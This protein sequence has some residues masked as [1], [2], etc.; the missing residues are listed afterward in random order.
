MK[1]YILKILL[2]CVLLAVCDMAVGFV[3]RYLSDH[4]KVGDMK[5]SNHVVR[6]VD[7]DVLLMGSSRCA[8]HYDPQIIGEAL[9]TSCYNI[10]FDGNGIFLMYGRYKLMSERYTPKMI[11]Y[12]VQY[13]FDVMQ[14]DNHKYLQ[15]LRPYYDNGS[16]KEIVNS[17]GD[18]ENIKMLSQCY[19]FNNQFV[20][21]IANNLTGTA[22]SNGL[23]YSPLDYDI[24]DCTAADVVD[25]PVVD[26]LK[27]YYMEQ[28][29]KD[30]QGKTKLVFCSSPRYL[31][32]KG[33]ETD[34]IAA[35]CEKYGVPFLEHY[36]D[37]TFT[38]KVEYF[39]DNNH[40]NR[41]GATAFSEV[42]A[43]E[44]ATIK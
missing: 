24:K 12:D 7:A 1:K 44:I 25:E 40:L 4:A 15:Y 6:E 28:L 2:F 34:C 19:R 43:R 18:H 9:G 3:G 8:H 11:I 14:N 42:I 22:G 13:S 38:T 30:C 21:L 27:L 31:Q 10:G 32:E 39:A 41:R 23:G 20:R 29:I 26:S 33:H 5:Q 17:V 36:S 37:T 16:V 35:L